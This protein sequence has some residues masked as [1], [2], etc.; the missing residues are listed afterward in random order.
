ML[1]QLAPYRVHLILGTVTVAWFSF[2]TL[3]G[4]ADGDSVFHSF[5]AAIKE[6]KP[7][8][9]V[10]GICVWMTI[11]GLIKQNDQLRAKIELL[12]SRQ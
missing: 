7:M 11:A 5:W 2:A 4:V 9:W 3:L 6:V 8:E 1:K 12:E 10:S